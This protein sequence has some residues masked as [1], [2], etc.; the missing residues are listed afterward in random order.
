VAQDTKSPVCSGS[1]P[2]TK[3]R[4]KATTTRTRE[5]NTWIQNSVSGS[6]LWLF[7]SGWTHSQR[8]EFEATRARWRRQLSITPQVRYVC[9]NCYQGF[10]TRHQR[11]PLLSQFGERRRRR[12]LPGDLSKT[13]LFSAGHCARSL[14]FFVFLMGLQSKLD[15]SSNNYASSVNFLWLG[16]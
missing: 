15:I 11:T 10:L 7:S 8:G 2:S 4:I 3:P 12:I 14:V 1:L 13:I 5:K 9:I 16:F 6:F